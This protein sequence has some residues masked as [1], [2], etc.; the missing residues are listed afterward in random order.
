[1]IKLIGHNDV[2]EAIKLMNKSTMDNEYKGFDRNE[3]V[4]ISFLLD[5]V[6]KQA[7]GSP[8]ALVIGDYDKT[9]NA[10]KGFLSASTFYSYYNT[11]CIMDVHDCIV[12]H[13][14]N[15]AY[16]VYRL[17]DYMIEHVKKHGGKAWRAD[18]IRPKKEGQAYAKFLARRYNTK[19]HVSVRG[20]VQENKDEL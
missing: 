6:K 1:M 11:D 2:F 20:V 17:F 10:L 18:S 13:D 5:L 16:V 3:T 15:N 4:W 7:E 12:N 9:T 14:Y 19:T 8:H